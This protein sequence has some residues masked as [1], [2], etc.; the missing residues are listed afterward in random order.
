M[1]EE[2]FD[3]TPGDASINRPDSQLQITG[4]I[5]QKFKEV[6]NSRRNQEG[7]PPQAEKTPVSQIRP[8]GSNQLEALIQG[9]RKQS[10]LHS[11]ITLPSMGLFYDGSDGPK[12]G[13][14]H[15]RPMTGEEEGILATPKFVKK[16]VAVNMI[17]KRCLQ[18][19]FNPENLLSVDRTYMLIFLRGISYSHEYEAEV[20]CPECDRKFPTT[21]NLN[22]LTVS[23]CPNNFGPHLSD[24]LPVSQ[25]EFN[26]HLPRGSD[27]TKIQDYREQQLRLFGDT[28]SDDTLTYRTALLIDDIKGLKDKMELMMLI[29]NLP[30]QD[31]SYLRNVINDPPFGVDTKCDIICP[32][33]TCEF[34][35]D[36]PLEANFFFP[37][38]RRKKV[39]QT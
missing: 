2:K 36:L 35:I 28:G 19:P 29:K 39:A 17:F 11:E 14:L 26:Y 1:S 4:K 18:E 21:I 38:P 6:L 15:M 9:L 3:Q 20:K 33:N 31:V 7:Q 5:P 16:G 13:K 34:Q 10:H 8:Q 12:D 37:R 24:V 27:E 32:Y 25:Y 23:N 22:D 30:V